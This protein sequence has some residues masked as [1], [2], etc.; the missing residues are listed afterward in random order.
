V[1]LTPSQ[2]KKIDRLGIQVQDCFLGVEGVK[3][4]VVKRL[5]GENAVLKTVDTVTATL[6]EQLQLLYQWKSPG[7]SESKKEIDAFLKWQKKLGKAATEA[8]LESQFSAESWQSTAQLIESQFSS[9]HPQERTL[10]WIQHWILY[11]DG[12]ISAV[13]SCEDY[14]Q[15]ASFTVVEL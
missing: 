12:W 2:Q 10:F 6:Q 15:D 13:C 14:R 4:L 5:L 11:G 1:V 3:D 8:Y 7:L 9:A